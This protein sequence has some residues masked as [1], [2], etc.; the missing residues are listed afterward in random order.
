VRGEEEDTKNLIF[1][2]DL[3]GFRRGQFLLCPLGQAVGVSNLPQREKGG[4][5][6]GGDSEAKIL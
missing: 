5:Q 4:Q 3:N 6:K 2:G 1:Q